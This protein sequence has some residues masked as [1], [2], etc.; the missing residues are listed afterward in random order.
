VPLQLL[1][2]AGRFDER[3]M[4]CPDRMRHFAKAGKLLRATGLQTLQ[5]QDNTV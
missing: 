3:F 2:I 1:V 5:P 4:K